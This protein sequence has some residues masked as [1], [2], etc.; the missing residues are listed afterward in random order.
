M[1]VTKRTRFEVLRRDGFR[2]YYCGARG[3]E[4]GAGLTIDHVTPTALGGTDDPSNLVSSC[5]ECNSGKASASLDSE[6]VSEIDRAAIAY[7]KAR[8]LA[9]AALEADMEAEEA[10][11]T[12]VWDAVGSTFPQY[13]HDRLR[14]VDSFAADWHR[15]GVP[16]AVVRKALRIAW[17]GPAAVGQKVRYAGGVVKHLLA[18]AEDRTRALAAGDSVIWK[19]GA[20]EG[21]VEGHDYAMWTA[22]QVVHHFDHLAQHIDGQKLEKSERDAEWMM[23]AIR[24]IPSPLV[25]RRTTDAA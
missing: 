6:T 18:D 9:M 14:D 7:S 4:T 20:D 23:H 25:Y 21:Y 2:C 1:A 3:T 19:A 17:E 16:I 8:A 10:Y 11:V 15:R 13:A 12:E 24:R 5:G 22:A